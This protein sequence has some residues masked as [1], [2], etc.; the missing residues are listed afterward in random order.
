MN[1]SNY[2]QHEQQGCWYKGKSY[3]VGEVIE[4]NDCDLQKMCS[5]SGYVSFGPASSTRPTEFL[6]PACNYSS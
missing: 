6:P 3:E 2:I 4:R 5:R 1:F